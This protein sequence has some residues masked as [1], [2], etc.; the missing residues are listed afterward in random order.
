VTILLAVSAT[1]VQGGSAGINLVLG[2]DDISAGA[3]AVVDL[4]QEPRMRRIEGRSNPSLF[5]LDGVHPID[6]GYAVL[7]AMLAPAVRRMS[8]T[9]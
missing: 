2:G 7:A 9:R 4:D 6:S 8:S 5:T 1:A 3:D